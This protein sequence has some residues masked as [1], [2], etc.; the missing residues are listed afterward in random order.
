[1]KQARHKR[2]NSVRLCLYEVLEES[3]TQTESGRVV[4]RGQE[5]EEK[6]NKVRELLLTEFV[7]YSDA[8]V[9]K[10]AKFWN[11]TDMQ[12]SGMKY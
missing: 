2:T 5:R 12:I 6:W 7:T 8:M 11:R 9:M 4:A 10:T 3:H 1:M